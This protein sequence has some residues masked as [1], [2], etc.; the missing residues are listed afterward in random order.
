MGMSISLGISIQGRKCPKTRFL[1]SYIIRW[2]SCALGIIRHQ[3]A[4]W[5]NCHANDAMAYDDCY[6]EQDGRSQVRRV[7]HLA[8]Y[9]LVHLV[10]EGEKVPVVVNMMGAVLTIECSM[11]PLRFTMMVKRHSYHHRY[12]NQQQ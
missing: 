6:P 5:A 2:C 4:L 12:V 1:L 11:S 10:L 3:L 7:L 8:E 9:A